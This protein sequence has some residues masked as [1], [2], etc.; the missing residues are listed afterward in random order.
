MKT[1]DRRC[2]GCDSKNLLATIEH[3]VWTEYE[4]LR[5]RLKVKIKNSKEIVK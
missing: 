4:C 2:P 1:Q 5:C 3:P